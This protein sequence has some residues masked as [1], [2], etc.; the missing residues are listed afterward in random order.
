[1]IQNLI[2]NDNVINV[3][4]VYNITFRAVCEFVLSTLWRKNS[5]CQTVLTFCYWYRT[6]GINKICNVF[7]LISP[8]PVMSSAS[9]DFVIFLA[10]LLLHYIQPIKLL[11]SH[12]NYV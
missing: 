7:L 1:L 12:V 10:L 8:Y 11:C 6:S 3:K 5:T 9:R 2:L 4:A